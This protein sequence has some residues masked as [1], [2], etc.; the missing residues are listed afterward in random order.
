MNKLKS[1][2]KEIE[3]Y[4]NYGT[5]SR[6][7]SRSKDISEYGEKHAKAQEWMLRMK[8]SKALKTQR[9]ITPY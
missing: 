3:G 2:T 8:D 7:T 5:E 9:G 4:G 1:R 6:L